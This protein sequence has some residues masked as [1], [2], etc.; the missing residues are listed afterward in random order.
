MKSD[1]TY[2]FWTGSVTEKWQDVS[3]KQRKRP[4]LVDGRNVQ[5]DHERFIQ[6]SEETDRLMKTDQLPYELARRNAIK[7]VCSNQN[8]KKISTGGGLALTT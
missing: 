7:N 4:V 2:Y 5:Q 8:S 6:V 1:G 3:G